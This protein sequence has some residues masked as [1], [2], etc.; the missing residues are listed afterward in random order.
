MSCWFSSIPRWCVNIV[1]RSINNLPLIVLLWTFWGF[2]R[3]PYFC[4]WPQIHLLSVWSSWVW[5]FGTLGLPWISLGYNHRV[6]IILPGSCMQLF[7]H[8]AFCKYLSWSIQIWNCCGF[9][10]S[11]G[12]LLWIPLASYLLKLNFI[13]SFPL[14]YSSKTRLPK[15]TYISPP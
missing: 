4:I 14:V 8:V 2:L 11:G 5:I 15:E 10:C 9:F 7:L 12:I 6:Q 3:P 1:F 13:Y